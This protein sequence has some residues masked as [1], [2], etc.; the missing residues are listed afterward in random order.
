M[1]ARARQVHL[2]ALAD[3]LAASPA[4]A[5]SHGGASMPSQGGSDTEVRLSFIH[6]AVVAFGSMIGFVKLVQVRL[7]HGSLAPT[8]RGVAVGCRVD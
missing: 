4:A 8:S 3:T 6:R 7:R 5:A 2:R 1:R